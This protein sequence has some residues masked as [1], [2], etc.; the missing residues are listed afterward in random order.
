[1]TAVDS[2]KIN[3]SAWT[4]CEDLQQPG[5]ALAI[6]GST[7]EVEWFEKTYSPY[8]TNATDNSDYYLGLGKAF[9]AN[10]TTD[11]LGAKLLSDAT[12]G[13]PLTWAA[14]ARAVPPIRVSG[15]SS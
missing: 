14:V 1:M 11:V 5:G 15:A 7:G 2:F 12:G 4:A 13:Q 3:G 6:V 9:V 8:G 10:A